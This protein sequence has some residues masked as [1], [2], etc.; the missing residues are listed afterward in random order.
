[1]MIYGYLLDN[2]GSPRIAIRN[3]PPSS[4][5][6]GLT[7]GT[8]RSAYRIVERS[9]QKRLYETTYYAESD[10]E[11]HPAILAVNQLIREEASHFLYGMHSFHF[12]GDLEAVIPFLS[13]R[14]LITRDLV[15]EITLHKKGP[16]ATMETD[17]G[18]WAA[19]CRFLGALPKFNKLRIVLEGGRPDQ[20]WD[21]PQE[22]SCSDL[23]FLYA[24]RHESMAWAR[25]LA[26]V[27]TATEVEVVAD[28]RRLAQPETT[29]TIVYAAFSA[30]IETTLVEFLRTE[31]GVPAKAG[32]AATSV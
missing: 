1:M 17:A 15:Q 23:R 9:L 31:L 14:T 21:G 12:A 6:F 10:G 28:L 8:R 16:L 5:T 27:K 22:L 24:T 3:K 19:I 30:S 32:P 2:G 4:T 29:A 26:E 25:A 18:A 13:D 11:M 7:Q 20:P